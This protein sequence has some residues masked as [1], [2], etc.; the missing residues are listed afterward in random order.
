MDQNVIP[1]IKTSKKGPKRSR[2]GDVIDHGEICGLQYEV[3]RRGNV[4]V[5]DSNLRFK[6]DA[7]VF[8]KKLVEVDI[9]GEEEYVIPG[10]GDTDDLVFS[11]DTRGNVVL[12]LRRKGVAVIDQLKKVVNKGRKSKQEAKS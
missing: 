11:N 12:T 5:F 4:H 2:D 6:K 9:Q 8:W 10:A 3:Y 7:D 1:F